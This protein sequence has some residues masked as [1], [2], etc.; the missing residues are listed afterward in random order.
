MFSFHFYLFVYLFVY[1]F[2]YF[3]QDDPPQGDYDRS[4]TIYETDENGMS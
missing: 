2:I 3:I 1:L 4:K